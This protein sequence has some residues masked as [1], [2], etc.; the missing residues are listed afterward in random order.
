MEENGVR[1][2]P[3]KEPAGAACGGPTWTEGWEAAPSCRAVSKAHGAPE[4]D[5]WQLGS[6]WCAQATC[7][8]EKEPQLE[9]VF[10]RWTEL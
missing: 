5:N 8:L 6:P 9:A 4:Q 3:W 10:S 2:R 1:R 7:S